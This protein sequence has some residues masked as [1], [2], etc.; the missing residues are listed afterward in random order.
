MS[1]KLIVNAITI[2]RIILTIILTV[3]ILTH[4]AGIL[5]YTILF[6]LICLTDLVDGR[7]AR[8]FSVC[9]S[10]GA[11]LDA[12]ADL[13]FIMAV[14]SSLVI[15]EVFPA[16]MLLVYTVKF[17]E[18]WATSSFLR[19]IHR[20]KHV[21]MFDSLGRKIAVLFYV[22]PYIAILLSAFLPDETVL[23]TMHL[24]CVPI[25][26]GAFISSLSRIRS[27]ISMRKALLS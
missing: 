17:L 25:T 8:K 27:C 2:S 4:S 22:M 16:W 6:L 5:P 11:V 24:L 21:F 23:L 10:F 26:V 15:A 1:Y 7:L 20:Q 18:F 14:S 9:T 12:M 13:F 19:R 3:Y